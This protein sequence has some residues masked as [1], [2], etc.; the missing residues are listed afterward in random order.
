MG[1]EDQLQPGEEILYRAHVTRISLI[2]WIAALVL[3]FA[4][5]AIAFHQTGEIAIAVAGGAVALVLAVLILV[6]LLVLRSYEHILT[7]RRLIQ[8]TGIL[9]KQSMDAP[10]DKVNNVEH[11]QTLWGRILGYGDVEIDTAS[12]HGATR[13]R[14]ISRPLEFKSAIVGAAEAYRSHRFAPPPA[15]V[16]APSGAERM[17]QLKALLDDGLISAEEYEAKRRKLLEEV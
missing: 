11:W 8:Q 12:E 7:N 15:A 16:S 10:L 2:P 13:F 3:A 17:R 9:R 14:S 4:G 5:A 1:V 6:K